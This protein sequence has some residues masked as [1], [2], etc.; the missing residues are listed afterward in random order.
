VLE[1][2]TTLG[3]LQIP[4]S[5]GWQNWTTLMNPLSLSQGKHKLRMYT[6]VGKFNLNWFTI[7]DNANS[8]PEAFLEDQ[9]IIYPNPVT[10]ILNI[11]SDFL[12]SEATVT[13]INQTGIALLTKEFHCGMNIMSMNVSD[14]KSGFYYVKVKRQTEISNYRFVKQ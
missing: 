2:V 13:I 11:R 6:D 5:G 7:S 14:L 12:T 10:D 8:T 4:S 9:R 3:T 1:N